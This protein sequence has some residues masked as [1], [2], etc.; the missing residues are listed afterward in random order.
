MIPCMSIGKPLP[1]DQVTNP[2]LPLLPWKH[3]L[4]EPA[5]TIST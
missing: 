1:L 2:Q 4:T 3:Q 5:D